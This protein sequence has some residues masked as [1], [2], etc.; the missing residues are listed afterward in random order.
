MKHKEK[1]GEKLRKSFNE[2]VHI[3]IRMASPVDI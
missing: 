3:S 2:T 1:I